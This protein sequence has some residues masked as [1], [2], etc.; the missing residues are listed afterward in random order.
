MP[1]HKRRKAGTVGQ[2]RLISVIGLTISLFVLGLIGLLRIGTSGLKG[3]IN[4]QFAVTVAAP[5]GY[6][7]EQL[8]SLRQKLEARPE[9]ASLRYITA[10]E[11]AAEVAESLGQTVSEMLL[12]LGEN[13][14]D[15]IYELH[16]SDSYVHRDSLRTFEVALEAEGLEVELNY[17]TDLLET[18]VHNTR[19]LEWLSWGILG[20]FLLLT[21]FQLSNTIRLFIYADRL[22]IR[23][24]T[25][26]GAKPW[27][28][29]AP[30]VGRAVLDGILSTVFA[31]VGL[32]GLVFALDRLGGLP[33]LS[34]LS[35]DYLLFGAGALLAVAVLS[36]ALS[37]FAATQR[38]IR[39]RSGLIHLD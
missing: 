9:V 4:N 7:A 32:A 2:M 21:Y 27:F 19:V 37:A 16:I 6:N 13:P 34:V 14:F 24:L 3:K 5:H 12:P 22:S 15:A 20:V 17:R 8:Q 35:L 36:T 25:L 29:R 23:I 30:F 11:A 28:V 39:M 10:E 38:Y 31:V 18:L 1:H 26:M 33:V